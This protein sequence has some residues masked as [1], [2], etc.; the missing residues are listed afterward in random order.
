MPSGC[1]LSALESSGKAQ[2]DRFT[3]GVIK[4]TLDKLVVY[5]G[6]DPG[7]FELL[8]QPGGKPYGT[9]NGQKVGVGIAHCSTLLVCALNRFGEIGIDV[10]RRDRSLH[11]SL[12][13]RIIHPDDECG[14]TDEFCG[15]RL[16]T[17]KEAV[18][19]YYGTGLR[20]A[21]NTIK[22]KVG[23]PY[24]YQ[25]ELETKTLAVTSFPFRDHWI[26]MVYRE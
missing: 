2:G 17:I 16:W 21:M 8:K 15:I 12:R 6:F 20:V 24:H 23:G 9:L 1:V 7:S 25:A 19:K 18:L 14:Q 22:L 4:A 26:A 5:E 11:P 10:E 13:K 3:A